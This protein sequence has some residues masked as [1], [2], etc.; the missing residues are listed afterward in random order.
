MA[1]MVFYE[2]FV[3]VS[4]GLFL[5]QFGVLSAQSFPVEKIAVGM[6]LYLS[7]I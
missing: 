4:A 1:I 3:L 6:Y 2:R 5:L 7:L